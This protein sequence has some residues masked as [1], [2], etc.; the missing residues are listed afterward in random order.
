MITE[1]EVEELL[2]AG[3]SLTVEFKRDVDD[4]ELIELVVCLANGEG[5][6]LLIGVDDDGTPVGAKPRHDNHTDPVRVQ[7]LIQNRTVP[8]VVT[9][10]AVV[11]VRGKEVLVIRVPKMDRLVATSG[12]KYLRRALNAKG[13]PECI[14]FY[15]HEMVSRMATLGKIDYSAVELEQV[16]WED[17]NPLEFERARQVIERYQGDRALLQLSDEELAKAL[18]VVEVRNNHLFVTV[19]GLLLFGREEA[20]RRHLPTHEVAFQVVEDG[21]V[22]VN[23]FYRAPLIRLSEEIFERF[24]ARNQEEELMLGLFRVGIPD[25]DPPAFREAVHNALIHRDYAQLGT[26]YIQWFP[27]RIE[28]SNPGGFVEGVRL[29]N[30]LVVPPKPRNP[31]LADAFRRLGL[32]ERTGRGVDMIFF[33]CLRYGRPAPD[34]GQSNETMVKVILPGGPAHREWTQWVIEQHQKRGSWPSVAELLILQRVRHARR[35][36]AAEAAKITQLSES[37]AR[38]LLERMVEWGILEARGER[39]GRFYHLSAAVYRQL[40]EKAAYVRMRG[41]E[42]IQMEQMILQYVR[43]HGR[44]TRKEAAELCQIKEHQAYYILQKLVQQG[45]VKLKGKGRSAHYVAER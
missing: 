31:R 41:F 29:D 11:T 30:L 45:R 2:S 37:E 44:I 27:D 6:W 38:S 10:V 24:K 12:G 43:A 8:S 4:N 7:A 21:R 34:Y 36:N 9:E 16:G 25:Y 28:V 5:G 32:V 15:P 19:T 20:L 23:G 1:H 39:R 17:L 13:R 35:I 40:G 42:T 22:V 3:E 14:P 33:G 26:V 18:G